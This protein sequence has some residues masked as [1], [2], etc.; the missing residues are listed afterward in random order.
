[1]SDRGRMRRHSIAQDP[2]HNAHSTDGPARGWEQSLDDPGA[3]ALR[4]QA[5]ARKDAV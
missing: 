2:A 1:M 4:K 5:H 3:A